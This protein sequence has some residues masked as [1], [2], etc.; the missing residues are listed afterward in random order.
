MDH[1]YENP[2]QDLLCTIIKRN[3]PVTLTRTM[4][5]PTPESS[6]AYEFNDSNPFHI[7]IQSGSFD[8]LREI[9]WIYLSDSELQSP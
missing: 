8:I 3:E 1:L 7:A 2:D 5:A 4:S 6:E 9:F